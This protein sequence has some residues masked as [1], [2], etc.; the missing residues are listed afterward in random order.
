MLASTT[1]GQTGGMGDRTNVAEMVARFLTPGPDGNALL[2]VPISQP[3]CCNGVLKVK[4]CVPLSAPHVRSHYPAIS[5]IHREFPSMCVRLIPRATMLVSGRNGIMLCVG[6]RGLDSA[7]LGCQYTRLSLDHLG[8]RTQFRDL[9]V[10]NLIYT[11]RAVPE[12][13]MGIDVLRIQDDTTILHAERVISSDYQPELFPALK[14]QVVNPTMKIVLFE[15]GAVN[16][17]GVRCPADVYSFYP[18]IYPG[19]R[20]TMRAIEADGKKRNRDR[21]ARFLQGSG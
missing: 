19:I 13:D 15:T 14:C 5:H 7:R 20:R 1:V 3:K 11:A 4:L 12:V 21:C 6:W 10:T 8:Y 2:D 16:F 17:T 9:A 18:Q